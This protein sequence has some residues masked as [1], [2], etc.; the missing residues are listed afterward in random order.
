MYK[1]NISV[2]N[3]IKG[4]VMSHT[5]SDFVPRHENSKFSRP[6]RDRDKDGR[7]DRG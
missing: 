6:G 4:Q 3:K 2:L 7:G 1:L 5:V